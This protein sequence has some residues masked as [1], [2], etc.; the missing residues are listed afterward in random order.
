MLLEGNSVFMVYDGLEQSLQNLIV[1]PDP[2][3]N[4]TKYRFEGP[5][6]DTLNQN[7]WGVKV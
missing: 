6:V 2:L 7:L 1:H 3:R 5:F 4:F